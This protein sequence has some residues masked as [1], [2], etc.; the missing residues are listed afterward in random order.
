[1]SILLI[2]GANFF[3]LVGPKRTIIGIL[4]RPIMCIIPLSIE[5]AFS[6]LVDKALTSG[7]PDKVVSN[8]GN[9]TLFSLF[10]ILSINSIFSFSIKKTGVLFFLV[11]SLATLIN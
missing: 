10:L 7:G 11:I 8:S 3:E 4:A 1:M 5:I 6:N 9:K 2:L